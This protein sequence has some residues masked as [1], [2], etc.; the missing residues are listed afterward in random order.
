M[1]FSFSAFCMKVL[2][3]LFTIQGPGLQVYILCCN[4]KILTPKADP[5]D[6]MTQKLIQVFSFFLAKE[7]N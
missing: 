2:F 1:G 7:N 6:C 3:T 4:G 5:Q